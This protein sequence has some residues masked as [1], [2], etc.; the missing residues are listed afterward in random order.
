MIDHAPDKPLNF[1]RQNLASGQL[2]K[3]QTQTLT[4]QRLD[5][6]GHPFVSGTGEASTVIL[7]AGPIAD[8]LVVLAS[9]LS[10]PG[11]G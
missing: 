7:G 3:F 10:L 6:A 11:L 2:L 9:S 1:R 4:L 8:A 5:R